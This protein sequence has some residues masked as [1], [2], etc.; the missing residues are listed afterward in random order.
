MKTKV[1]IVILALAAAPAATALPRGDHRGAQGAVEFTCP[2]GAQAGTYGS[3][4]PATGLGGCESVDEGQHG[5]QYNAAS[6]SLL[7]CKTDDVAEGDAWT[8]ASQVSVAWVRPYLLECY[9]TLTAD[10]YAMDWEDSLPG[11]AVEYVQQHCY[12]IGGW[13]G[14]AGKTYS[15]WSSNLSAVDDWQVTLTLTCGSI[16]K[17]WTDASWAPATA[18]PPA[19]ALG[20]AQPCQLKVETLSTLYATGGVRQFRSHAVRAGVEYTATPMGGGGCGLG[21]ELV[22]LLPLLRGLREKR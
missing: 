2:L 4:C 12:A 1:L 14:V 21:I 15:A 11:T 16:V 7:Y 13:D 9:S 18:P 5:R 3:V 22:A 17:T 10:G 8:H 6:P 20:S 19:I